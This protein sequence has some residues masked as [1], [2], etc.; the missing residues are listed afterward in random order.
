MANSID[1]SIDSSDLKEKLLLLKHTLTEKEI[2]RAI[3]LGVNVAA[4]RVR[5]RATRA[6]R[7]KYNIRLNYLLG[8]YINIIKANPG[9]LSASI[10]MSKKHIPIGAFLKTK[11]YGPKRKRKARSLGAKGAGKIR[12]EG[13]I[14]VEILEGHTEQIKGAFLFNSKYNTDTHL[15]V[16]HRSNASNKQSYAG[17]FQFRHDRITKGGSDLTIGAMMSVSPFQTVFNDTV[18]R[19]IRTEGVDILQD[20]VYR[21]LIEIGNGLIKNARH[22]GGRAR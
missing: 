14:S 18:S 17:A 16:M 15:S 7:A 1:I 10:E 22:R 21:K 9:K 19:V 8:S 13:G 6:I 12:S 4:T 3:Y 20:Q 11:A 2:N 5:T